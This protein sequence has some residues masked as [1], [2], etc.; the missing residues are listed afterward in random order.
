MAAITPAPKLLRHLGA[1]LVLLHRNDRDQERWARNEEG[2]RG[3]RDGE[4]ETQGG[5]AK[6]GLGEVMY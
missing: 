1:S 4:R 2:R 3:E 6:V 5:E